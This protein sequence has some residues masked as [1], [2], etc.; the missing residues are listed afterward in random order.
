[1]QS[2]VLQRFWSVGTWITTAVL[3]LTTSLIAFWEILL[4]RDIGMGLF[5][6]YASSNANLPQHILTGQAN[7]IGQ[8]FVII[9][10]I[11]AILIVP[12]GAEFHY[13]YFGKPKSWYMF[14]VVFFFQ[15]VVLI[16]AS[17]I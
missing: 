14:G 17:I 16:L 1:M 6:N 9:G 7:V 5:L 15:I 12:G 10:A 3:W 2:H 8:L 4:I 13:Q 11:A